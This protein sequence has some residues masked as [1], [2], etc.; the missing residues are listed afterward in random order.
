[1][2]IKPNT[3]V[4]TDKLK[5]EKAGNMGK[6]LLEAAKKLMMRRRNNLI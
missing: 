3:K 2:D 4:E 5:L 6:T 1:M